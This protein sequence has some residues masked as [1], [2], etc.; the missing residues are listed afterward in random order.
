VVDDEVHDEPDVPVVE[1][2]Q[3]RLEVS[4]PPNRSSIAR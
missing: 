4:M 3:Q 2:R 1:R